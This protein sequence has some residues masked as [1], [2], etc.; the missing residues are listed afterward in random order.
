MTLTPFIKGGEILVAKV[1]GKL[2]TKILDDTVD[3]ASSV[4]KID[5]DDLNTFEAP[6]SGKPSG[7]TVAKVEVPS[8]SDSQVPAG[9]SLVKRES[10]GTL[11]MHD[12]FDGHA[13]QLHVGKTEEQ[14]LKR[15]DETPHIKG[16]GTFTDMRSADIAVGETLNVKQQDIQEWLVGDK[17]KL[18][19]N[20]NVGRDIGIVIPRGGNNSSAAQKVTVILVRDPSMPQGYL[21]KTAHPEL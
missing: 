18:E 7:G 17:V 1:G 2:A 4:A 13:V 19:L 5:K 20:H 9:E 12:N 21:I 16:S 10:G 14:L 15:F 6:V 11:I 3:T 8:P